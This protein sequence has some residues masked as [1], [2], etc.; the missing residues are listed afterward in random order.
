MKYCIGLMS[1]TSLDGVDAVLIKIN[2]FCIDTEYEEVY[3]Q[4]FEMP[5]VQKNM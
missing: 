3:F 4:C 5:Q 2:N 1:G